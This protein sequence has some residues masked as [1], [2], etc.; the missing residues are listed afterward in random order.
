MALPVVHKKLTPEIHPV[1]YHKPLF[2]C[3]INHRKVACYCTGTYDRSRHWI[4]E[5]GFSLLTA[6]VAVPTNSNAKVEARL[7]LKA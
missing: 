6:S 4:S 1:P 3:I 7:S 2:S 5:G